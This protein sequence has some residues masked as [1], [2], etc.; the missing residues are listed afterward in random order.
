LYEGKAF[1]RR[2]GW[3]VAANAIGVDVV[4]GLK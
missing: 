4:L 1:E 3:N 2:E